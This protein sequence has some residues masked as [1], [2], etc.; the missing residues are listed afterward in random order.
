MT[1][2]RKRGG[3]L[4]SVKK[5]GAVNCST[6]DQKKRRGKNYEEQDCRLKK[7]PATHRSGRDED[8]ATNRKG[9]CRM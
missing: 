5:N 9:Y 2:T 1:K 3:K 6:T 4:K 8:I 7:K